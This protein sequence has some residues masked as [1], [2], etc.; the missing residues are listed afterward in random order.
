MLM[1]IKPLKATLENKAEVKE[2]KSGE[3]AVTTRKA[4][5]KAPAK[6]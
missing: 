6:K 4:T 1:L 5:K 2:V 3:T